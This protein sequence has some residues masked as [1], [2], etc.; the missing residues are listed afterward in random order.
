ML[1]ASAIS[2]TWRG[3]R[4]S[5]SSRPALDCGLACLLAGVLEVQ[6][7]AGTVV[8]HRPFGFAGSQRGPRL[9]LA[10]VARAVDVLELGGRG[11][12]C[13]PVEHAAGPD[14][15]ELPAVTDRDELRA[16]ALD[17]VDDGVQAL[18]VDH[19]GLVKEHGRVGAD[20]ERSRFARAMRA[21]R[22]SVRP[23]SAGL[24]APSRSAVEP[25]TAT[26]ITSR[27]TVCSARA[28]ASI[29]TPLP[30]PAGPISSARRSGPDK[31]RSAVSCSRDRAPP[32]RSATS[33]AAISRATSPTSLS[34]GRASAAARRSIACSRART[35]RVVIRPPSSMR[36]RRSATIE[37]AS[38]S[39]RSGV[40]TPA[41][42]SS[43][44]AR[45]VPGSKIASRSVS[46]ASITSSTGRSRTAGSGAPTSRT[47]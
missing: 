15:G 43:A 29:T 2:A 7:A 26:P 39:A 40:M 19:P 46:F 3:S 44:T 16:R 25:D 18:V 30:V 28:A 45:S 37:R 11:A 35:A 10:G 24:P 42:C 22:V 8:R 32:I 38:W 20:L 21:S 34:A 9:A 31:A 17:Q 14:R 4:V 33:R 1:E 13:E 12:V 47:A 27:P 36:M 41:V 23:A 5:V 6:L